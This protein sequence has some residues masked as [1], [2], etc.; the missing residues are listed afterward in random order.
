M[1]FSHN[2]RKLRDRV[3][4]QYTDETGLSDWKA[5]EFQRWLVERGE[6]DDARVKEAGTVFGTPV[7]YARLAHTRATREKELRASRTMA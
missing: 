2:A 4:Q 3:R 6:L 5:P 1:G 7:S